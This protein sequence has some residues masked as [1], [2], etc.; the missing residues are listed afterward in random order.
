LPEHVNPILPDISPCLS[1]P[2]SADVLS[3]YILG[4]LTPELSNDMITNGAITALCHL[5]SELGPAISPDPV[6]LLTS[7]ILNSREPTDILFEQ[8]RDILNSIFA[9]DSA[10]E[11]ALMIASHFA[12]LSP[13]FGDPLR[14]CGVVA[15]SERALMT[16]V[17]RIRGRALDFIAN[18]VR[19]TSPDS[20]YAMRVIDLILP[21]IAGDDADCRKLGALALSN[22]LFRSPELV[23]DI[24]PRID[25]KAL[26]EMLRSDD[27][28][29]VENAAGLCGTLVRRG[30]IMIGDFIREGVL[31]AIVEAIRRGGE[32]GGRVCLHLTLFCQWEE[33]RARLKEMGV[34]EAAAR[35]AVTGNERVKKAA[36]AIVNA[37]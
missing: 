21:Q 13:D 32:V 36:M 28:K 34:K 31:M 20:E 3:K 2:G 18:Y 25:L 33:A 22:L 30:R 7:L 10:A 14:E 19:Q 4:V 29:A 6:L 16:D 26:L 15:L 1:V 23:Q 12:R 11:S 27:P 17:P 8:S 35:Y 24:G 37:L 5:I 9:L